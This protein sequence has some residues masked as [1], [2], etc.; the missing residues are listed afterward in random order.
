M[1]E[2]ITPR[3]ATA[4]RISVLG[5]PVDVLDMEATVE[6]VRQAV[7]TRVSVRH[8]CVSAAKLTRMHQ[9]YALRLA[10]RSS[11]IIS[12]DGAGVLWAARMLRQPVP[13]RVTGIALFLRLVRVAANS[14]WPIFLLGDRE[15]VVSAVGNKLRHAYPGL[16]VAGHHHGFFDDEETVVALI[17]EARPS[18][19]FAAM[20]TPRQEVFLHAYHHVLQVPFSM[21]VGGSFS[22]VANVARRTPPAFGDRGLEWLHRLSQDPSR[23]MRRNVVEHGGFISKVVRARLGL[24]TSEHD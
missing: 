9:E 17:R 20:G 13:P 8:S 12:A 6:R 16:Q 3:M 18:L 24:Y 5:C 15:S 1:R 22:V 21:G 4:S 23:L 14:G 2:T 10:V 11:D 19:L 7:Q